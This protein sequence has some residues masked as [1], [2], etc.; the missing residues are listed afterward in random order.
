MPILEPS[1]ASIYINIYVR[2]YYVFSFFDLI[3]VFFN[4]CVHI[5]IERERERVCV[6]RKN[7]DVDLVNQYTRNADRERPSF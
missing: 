1:S 4:T 6:L 7:I 5:C 3:S 2:I